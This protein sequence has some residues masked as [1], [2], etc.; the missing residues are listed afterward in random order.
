MSLYRNVEL[1]DP[2]YETDNLRQL[3]FNSPALK[4]RGDVT[5]FVPPAGS[6]NRAVI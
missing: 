4:G 1:S 5:I 3:T 2:Q 6:I